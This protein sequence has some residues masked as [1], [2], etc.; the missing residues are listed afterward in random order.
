MPLRGARI[1]PPYEAWGAQRALRATKRMEMKWLPTVIEAH[2]GALQAGPLHCKQWGLKA[3]ILE[4]SDELYFWLALIFTGVALDF[5]W[6][7]TIFS[8]E[9]RWIVTGV[10]LDFHWNG[11]GM[12]GIPWEFWWCLLA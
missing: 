7:G 1:G 8:L 12:S 9:W 2:H 5:H 4:L 10:A 11:T 6:N 3:A